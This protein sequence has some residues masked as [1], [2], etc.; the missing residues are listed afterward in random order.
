MAD[1]V[2]KAEFQDLFYRMQDFCGHQLS[3][4]WARYA[5]AS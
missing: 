4:G 5:A 2:I 3:R 1:D